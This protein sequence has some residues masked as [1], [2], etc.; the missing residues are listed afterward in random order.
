MIVVHLLK[1]KKE[2]E[3]LRRQEIHVYFTKMIL[4]KLVF[5]M[6]WLIVNQK[7]W[8][9]RTESY[10]F[11]R[12]RDNP[13]Y[14]RYQRGLGSMFYRFFLTK[15]VLVEQLNPT[16]IINLQM[17]FIYVLLQILVD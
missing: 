14:D 15:R 17:N 13:K 6:I 3:N 5:N 12:V 9:K 10:T 7:T 16:Q 11:L 4:I 1:T 2:M 8:A